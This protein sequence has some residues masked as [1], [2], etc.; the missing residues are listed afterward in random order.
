MSDEKE[1]PTSA[2]IDNAA[3]KWCGQKE[4]ETF[5]DDIVYFRHNWNALPGLKKFVDAE[6]AIRTNAQERIRELDEALKVERI[7]N[8]DH[9]SKIA[10]L[11][12]EFAAE[13]EQNARISAS[14]DL[15]SGDVA[16]F[17]DERKRVQDDILASLFAIRKQW[18]SQQVA[19][20]I[21]PKVAPPATSST[22]INDE[23]RM[24]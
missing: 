16:T 24:R 21:S 3:I 10:W 7:A 11:Q 13:R 17:A 23:T 20:A 19:D 15:P 12:Q 6:V 5:Y 4:R 22:T 2:E 18:T 8:A 9:V 14:A 1:V